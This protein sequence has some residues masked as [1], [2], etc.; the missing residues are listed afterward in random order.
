MLIINELKISGIGGIND[1]TVKFNKGLNLICGPNGVG[2]TTI[3]ESIAE[4]FSNGENSVLKRNANSQEGV[5]KVN[6]SSEQGENIDYTYKIQN[7]APNETIG[8]HG[9]PGDIA[10][11]II[12]FKTQRSFSYQSLPAI[13]RDPER[14]DYTV[15][16][17]ASAG[18]QFDE[19]KNWFI[20]RYLFNH[21]DK[22]LNEFQKKNLELAIQCFGILDE[23]VRFKTV[24][25]DTFDIFLETPNGQIYFEYLSSG[26]KSC[27]FI[28]QGLIKEIEFRF[29]KEKSIS[30]QDF[31]GLIL[32]D[33]LDLHLHPHWQSKLI[34]L[35]K[36]VLPKAQIIATTHSPHMIQTAEIT[37]LIPLGTNQNGQVTVRK[38]PNSPYGFQ[39]WTVEEILIDVM[40]LES[41][42][43]PI[44]TAS[45]RAFEKAIE[46][47]DEQGVLSTYTQLDLMLHPSN[48]LRKVL[49]LQLAQS[50]GIID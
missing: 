20:N 6:A 1:L 41:T 5:C 37:E 40:G 21:I 16:K 50:G 42:H 34:H 15:Y 11:N 35:L 18:T 3:L 22:Q 10:Y 32:I 39:G 46:D 36:K 9:A 4:I 49:K 33:E 43:S 26:F 38:L 47:G 19:F 45:L 24:Q 17:S 48:P 25:G 8:W 7:F 44:Y 2:K 14:D 27:L 13:S 23:N 12:Y 31:Q 29:K 28:I 30:V